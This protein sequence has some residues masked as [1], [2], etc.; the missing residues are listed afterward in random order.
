MSKEKEEKNTMSFIL[1]I[2]IIVV[3]M[4]ILSEA[5]IVY[6]SK[7]HNN[8]L[9]VNSLNKPENNVENTTLDPLS[10]TQIIE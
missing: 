3:S 9:N 4:L 6:V 2:V 7:T 10:N 1:N 8:F 5:Y